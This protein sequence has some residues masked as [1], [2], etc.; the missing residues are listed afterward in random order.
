MKERYAKA[1]NQWMDDFTNNPD[2]FKD[3]Y[4]SA[5]EYLKEKLQGKEPSYGDVCAEQF[6]QY[7][8]ATK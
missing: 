4:D 2:T 1:F 3:T 5:L 8:E 7:L 6:T